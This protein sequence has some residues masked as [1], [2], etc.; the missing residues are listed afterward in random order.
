MQTWRTALARKH[1]RTLTAYD[2]GPT[3]TGLQIRA[4]A[5]AGDPVEMLIY[6][7]IGDDGWGDGIAPSDVIG[8]LAAAGSAPVHVRI[9]SPGGSVFDGFAIYNALKTHAAGVDVTVDGIAAS[10]ASFIAMAGRTITMGEQSMMMIHNASTLDFGNK[11][12]LA[13]TVDLLGKIDNQLVGIYAARTRGLPANI[14]Q[15]M[16]DETYMT[17][18][19]AKAQGFCDAV[20]GAD[21][22][23]ATAPANHDK[24]LQ[25]VAETLP[26]ELFAARQRAA[27][28]RTK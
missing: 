17:S 5:K 16:T 21:P 23:P 2:A 8:A 6:A 4:A 18:A 19:E 28:A 26:L 25:P 27:M 11:E 20:A 22:V 1:G 12:Q 9:N 7:P 13:K 14:A 24:P 3:A 10:A 15:M